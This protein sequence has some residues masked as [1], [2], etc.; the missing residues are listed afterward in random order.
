[1]NG[2]STF[3]YDFTN[4]THISSSYKFTV[5]PAMGYMGSGPFAIGWYFNPN[6]QM[7]VVQNIT[8]N[9]PSTEI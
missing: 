7:T 9:V 3:T 2:V 5:E 6:F 1:M 4:A 8:A